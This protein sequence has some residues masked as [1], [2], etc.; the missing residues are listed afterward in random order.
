MNKYKNFKSSEFDSPDLKGS[1]ENMQD[2]FMEKLQKG[3]EIAQT[4]FV[5]T[6]GFRTK[7]YQE[8]LRKRGYKTSKTTSPHETGHACDISCKDSK[9]RWLIIGSL[10]LAGFTRFGIGQSFIHVDDCP[11]RTNNRIWTY[12]Y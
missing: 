5:I 4:P 8:D 6:S 7:N 1:G 2:S 12:E 3:R 9:T 10:M 11:K